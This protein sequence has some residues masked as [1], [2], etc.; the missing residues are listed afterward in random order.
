MTVDLV[1]KAADAGV[2]KVS[3]VQ[4]DPLRDMLRAVGAGV[5]LS[6]VVFV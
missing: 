6:L 3:L 1:E 4:D 2:G 5:G